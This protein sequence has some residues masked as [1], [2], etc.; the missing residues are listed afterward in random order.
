MVFDY[1]ILVLCR[2]NMLEISLMGFI[3]STLYGLSGF[4]ISKVLHADGYSNTEYIQI[5]KGARVLTIGTV[6]PIQV[7]RSAPEYTYSGTR[8]TVLSINKDLKWILN[9][10]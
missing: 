7:Y 2:M 10:E 4:T 5:R 6:K 1:G 8:N 3:Q 9:Q